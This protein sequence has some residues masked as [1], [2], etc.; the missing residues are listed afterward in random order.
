MEPGAGGRG[1]SQNSAQ[2]KKCL[3]SLQLRHQNLLCSSAF[4]ANPDPIVF[5]MTENL[6]KQ[7]KRGILKQSTS[8][9]QRELEP[10]Q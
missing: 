7:P 5:S 8:F 4:H 3:F 10:P 6:K 1:K 2:S 9:E